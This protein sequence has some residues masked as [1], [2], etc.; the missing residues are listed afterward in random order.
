MSWIVDQVAD[1]GVPVITNAKRSS[2]AKEVVH[3]VRVVDLFATAV[4]IEGA[5][6]ATMLVVGSVVVE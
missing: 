6:A 3:P 5:A 4:V 2:A 1:D